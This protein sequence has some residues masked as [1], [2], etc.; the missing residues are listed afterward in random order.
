[1]KIIPLYIYK[2]NEEVIYSPTQL[3]LEQI[4]TAYRLIAEEG[5]LV[6][7]GISTGICLDVPNLN[8]TG[9]ILDTEE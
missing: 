5:Y 4:G 9:E 7:D 8:T 2:H 1:M 6:T 3:A